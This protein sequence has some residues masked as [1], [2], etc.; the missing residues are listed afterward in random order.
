M[1]HPL[2]FFERNYVLSLS[3]RLPEELLRSPSNRFLY[4]EICIALERE[5]R[6]RTCGSQIHFTFRF[7]TTLTVFTLLK[8]ICEALIVMYKGNFST[9]VTIILKVLEKET[10]KQSVPYLEFTNRLT[11]IKNR[12]QHRKVDQYKTKL[13]DLLN[14]VLVNQGSKLVIYLLFYLIFLP[15]DYRRE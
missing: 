1:C 8:K 5:G 10:E 12:R 11:I 3:G 4:K 13:L 15:G 7:I 9:H 2:L 14:N 6:I